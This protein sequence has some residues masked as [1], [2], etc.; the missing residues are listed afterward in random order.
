[1][2]PPEGELTINQR[3]NCDL[4]ATREQGAAWKKWGPYLSERQ[5]GTVRED[6]SQDGDAW[7]Y[8][9]HDQA[10]SR[11][12]HWGEDGMAGI[13]DDR[14]RLCFAWPCGTAR[15]PILKE[16]MFGLTN[17]EGNHGEDVKEY[18]FYLDSTP[19]PLLHEVPVQ[20]SAGGISLRRPGG[21]QPR[22]SRNE[23]EYEL[24]DTGVF[25][26][27]R[28]FD[29]FVEYAKAA[30]ED[31][32]IRISVSN[33]GPDAAEMH[34]LPTLWFRNNWSWWPRDGREAVVMKQIRSRGRRKC[35]R[36]TAYQRW[37]TILVLRGRC[38]AA[39]HG[40]RNQQRAALRHAQLRPLTSKTA[41]TTTWCRATRCGQPGKQGTKAAA[42]Y[43]VTSVPASAGDPTAPLPSSARPKGPTASTQFDTSSRH[44]AR[45]R[46]SST[47]RSLR[48]RVTEDAANVMRQA[49]A[50]MLWTKQY[51]FFDVDK[52]LEEHG[53]DPLE[54]EDR[55]IR[56]R[57]WFHM[58]N[59]DIISMPDKWEY[60]WYAAWDLAFHTYRRW[61][62]W[63][64][65][66]PNNSWN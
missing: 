19:H 24:L 37:A 65:S 27:D 18:Y 35:G 17:S 52:W 48:P 59:Q 54:P 30:P 14:Q 29:V 1:M 66:L 23:M 3:S 43:Q 38:A 32:L 12:Y 33:R 40:E 2:T 51:F 25:N 10:R 58:V 64:S 46:T 20:V 34:V 21:D 60:P 16:R 41:S 63:I 61:R 28:Y 62:S 44:A 56:N 11:A 7:D 4:Q 42:H 53:T 26:E 15:I 47:S 45:R 6:Y 8:F 49:L 57:E 13:C 50:G 31:I 36:R 39:I 9:T 55:K 22:R 5:W